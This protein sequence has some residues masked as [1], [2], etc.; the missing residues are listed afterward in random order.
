MF[1]VGNQVVTV[2]SEAS[3]VCFTFSADMPGSPRT[4]LSSMQALRDKTLKALH[5]LIDSLHLRGIRT[6]YRLH[7]TANGGAWGCIRVAPFMS[8][9]L[10]PNASFYHHQHHARSPLSYSPVTPSSLLMNASRR[11]TVAGALPTAKASTS[12]GAGPSRSKTALLDQR[13]MDE[14]E[15]VAERVKKAL[16]ADGEG[17]VEEK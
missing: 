5:N 10:G 6:T 7:S 3:F 2:V 1:R 17:V 4:D 13:E 9:R 11:M 15:Q 16:M 12:F 14:K 8:S